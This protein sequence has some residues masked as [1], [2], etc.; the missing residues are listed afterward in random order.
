MKYYVILLATYN[1][2]TAPKKAIYEYDTEADAVA[3][4]HSYMGTYMKDATVHHVC[5]M[6]INDEG[7]IYENGVF[8]R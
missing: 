8:T 5:V 6:A 1:N 7:G 4:F 2:G 3:N